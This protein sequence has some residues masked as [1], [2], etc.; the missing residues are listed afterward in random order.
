M[1]L[2][3]DIH[4]MRAAGVEPAGGGR[5]DEV[6]RRPGYV[7]QLGGAQGDDRAKQLL[8]VGVGRVGEE[9]ARIAGLDDL[10]RVHHRDPVAGLGDD[11][12]VVGDQQQRGVEVAPQVGED[13]EDLGL[14]DHVECRCR[15]VGDHQA[16]LQDQRQRDHDPLPHAARE[17]VRVLTEAGR[18]DAHS[19]K[20]LQR[21]AP[22]LLVIEFGSVRAQGLREVVLDREQGVEPGH[23]LLEDQPQLGAAQ[24]TQLR[25]LQPD[26]VLAAEAHLAG[27]RRRFGQQAEY[28]AAQGRLAAARLAHKPHGLA[29]RDVERDTVDGAHRVALGAVP[30]PQVAQGEDR[31]AHRDTRRPLIAPPPVGSA[32]GAGAGGGSAG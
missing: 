25:R 21:S 28:A 16:R 19:G 22:H 18:R 11:A 23:R 6:R 13:G 30:D 5:V 32:A 12:E 10:A 29:G 15:L 27:G 24:G 4:R 2:G 1:L 20:C 3:A 8:R 14:D 31:V 7:V 17:L 9:L 26:Q